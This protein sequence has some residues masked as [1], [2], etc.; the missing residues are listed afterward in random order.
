MKGLKVLWLSVSIVVWTATYPPAVP[1]M[2]QDV[3]RACVAGLFYP[4]ETATLEKAEV[5]VTLGEHP[6][7]P[8]LAYLGVSYQAAMSGLNFEGGEFPFMEMLPKGWEGE[9]GM[10]KFFFH[11]G[12]EFDGERPKD[13]G[14]E[15]WDED[16]EFFFHG[17][18]GMPFGDEEGMPHFF[19]LGRSIRRIRRRH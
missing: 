11:H 12:D 10:P 3:R 14:S 6:E 15:G 17:V 1:A 9:E 7:K 2:K 16:G 19:D 4:K 13:W 8:G 5:I 18:P